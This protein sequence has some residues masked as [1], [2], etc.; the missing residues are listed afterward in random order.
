MYVYIYIYIHII[1]MFKIV[2]LFLAGAPSGRR[3]SSAPPRGPSAWRSPCFRYSF[4]FSNK[5]S[6]VLTMFITL[7]EHRYF[8]SYFSTSRPECAA[9]SWATRRVAWRSAF[10]VSLACF[11]VFF[12]NNFGVLFS[13]P[14]PAFQFS[15]VNIYI[16]FLLGHTVAAA[17]SAPA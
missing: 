7:V 10:L 12:C 3:R 15:F 11:S 5:F 9:E 4:E 6:I 16:S 1:H 8:C 17:S 2:L 13:F 14:F